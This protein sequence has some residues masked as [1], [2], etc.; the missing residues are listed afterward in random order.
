MRTLTMLTI[1]A[2]CGLLTAAERSPS[3]DDPPVRLPVITTIDG[4]T[5][6]G[7]ALDGKVIVVEFWA[8]WCGPCVGETPHLKKLYK[9]YGGKG[10]VFI[11]LAE[12]T[13]ADAVKDYV[14]QHQ[15]PWHVAL[16]TENALAKQLKVKALPRAF[17]LGRDRRIAWQGVPHE[18]DK[19]LRDAATRED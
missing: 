5:L 8:T 13:D 12:E 11:G 4:K 2:A 10:V 14:K 15:I 19:A 3:S 18:M 1:L 9:E 16:D 6:D 17:I 7:P